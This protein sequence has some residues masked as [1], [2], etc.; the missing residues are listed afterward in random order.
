MMT[1]A[2]LAKTFRDIDNLAAE[3]RRSL[4]SREDQKI[5]CGS[6][7]AIQMSAQKAILSM[8]IDGAVETANE[9]R[10][11]IAQADANERT[12]TMSEHME[13]Q[14]EVSGQ[15]IVRGALRIGEIYNDAARPCIVADHNACLGIEAPETTVPKLREAC[16]ELI[17][18]F[19]ECIS[20][21][22]FGDGQYAEELLGAVKSA[23]AE[24]RKN[25]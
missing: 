7:V 18:D 20:A 17:A 6:F 13:K 19:D 12:Q 23:L 14:W 9:V 15:Y 22:E 4:E 3:A 25:T 24:M 5:A 10:D 16:T 11:A 2:E 1:E 8:Q 21:S